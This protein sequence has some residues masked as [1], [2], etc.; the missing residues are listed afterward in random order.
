MYQKM[1]NSEKNQPDKTMQLLERKTKEV[2]IIQQ[3]SAEI[4]KT[5]DL[6][7][8]GKSML[9]AMD[10]YFG[11]QHSM[12]LL[13]DNENQSLSVLS[14]H[15][16]DDKGIGAKVPVGMGVIGM[17]AKRK[18]LMRMANMGMQ[19]SYMQAIRQQVTETDETILQ[20]EEDLPGLPDVESQVAIPMLLEEE[21][22]G[23]F[24][25]ESKQVNIF[26]KAD[27]FLIGILA[28]QAASALQNARLFQREQQR[29]SEL[30]Q[31]HSDLADLN[32]NLEKKVEERT[33]E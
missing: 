13:M 20:E 31:A 15:G 14:T 10:E 21:L 26:D 32:A 7:V 16:Y 11:F 19:R 9:L 8:I 2:D 3:V 29:L 33:A 30:N 24:S 25:F 12:I 18:K 1:T 5:L 6:A 28:N 22:V 23:V 4:N 27:E 17:V